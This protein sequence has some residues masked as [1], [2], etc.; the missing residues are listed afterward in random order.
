MSTAT[1]FV[2]EYVPQIRKPVPRTPRVSVPL[3]EER[4]FGRETASGLE[5]EDRQAFAAV[6]WILFA[7][8]STGCLLMA[9]AVL[10]V[11]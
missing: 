6:S 10:W 2:R 1:T 3:P 9:G 8:V 7:I 11:I 4:V 5:E